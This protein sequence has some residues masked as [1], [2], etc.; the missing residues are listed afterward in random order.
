[1]D[2]QEY[3]LNH[4]CSVAVNYLRNATTKERGNLTNTAHISEKPPL[5]DN[6]RNCSDNITKETSWHG[7]GAMQQQPVALDAPMSDHLL[8]LGAS[9]IAGGDLLDSGSAVIRGELGLLASLYL[10][11]CLCRL[12]C[13]RAVPS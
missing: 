9:C 2:E 4:N 7:D 1:M 8:L 11:G 5:T 10:L 6:D 3:R 12:R 13:T